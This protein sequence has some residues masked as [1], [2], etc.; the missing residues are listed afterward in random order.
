[1]PDNWGYVV[2]AYGL[3]ALALLGYWRYLVRRARAVNQGRRR[4]IRT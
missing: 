3:G 1:M 4:R 2:A